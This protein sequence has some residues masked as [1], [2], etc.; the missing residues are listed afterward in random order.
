MINTR[1]VYIGLMLIA[2]LCL[3]AAVVTFPALA[4]GAVPPI[5]ALLVVSLIIDICAMALVARNGSEPVSMNARLTGFFGAAA[6][7][8]LITIMAG[9][10]PGG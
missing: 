6:I 1:N 3:G 10:S 8:L 9:V 5:A 7:Y 2:G 4:A